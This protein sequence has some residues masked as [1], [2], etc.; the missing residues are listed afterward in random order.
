MSLHTLLSKH[1]A[2]KVSENKTVQIFKRPKYLQQKTLVGRNK[3]DVIRTGLKM[4][5]IVEAVRQELEPE[6][7]FEDLAVD[8]KPTLRSI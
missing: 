8:Q 7:P 1:F 3:P 6:D 2:Q 4:A 5:G